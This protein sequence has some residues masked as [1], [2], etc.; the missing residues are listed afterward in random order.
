MD[1]EVFLVLGPIPLIPGLFPERSS[2]DVISRYVRSAENRGVLTS[3]V[4]VV[5]DG[6]TR[7]GSEF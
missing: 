6:C 4:G 5:P 1:M 7:V 2:L 3:A